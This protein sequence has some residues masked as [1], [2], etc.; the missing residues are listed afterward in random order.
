M[1]PSH[2]FYALELRQ[3]CKSS[4]QLNQIGRHV[5]GRIKRETPLPEQDQA[6]E[7]ALRDSEIARQ[8]LQKHKWFHNKRNGDEDYNR[9]YMQNMVTIVRNN[10]VK[11]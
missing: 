9:L 6:E 5:A 11:A 1:T 4:R 8:P 7:V 2:I 3:H 10:I